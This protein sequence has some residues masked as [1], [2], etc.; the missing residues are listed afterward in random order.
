MQNQQPN[1]QIQMIPQ[2]MQLQ[3]IQI[4]PSGLSGQASVQGQQTTQYV[5]SQDTH[6]QIQNQIMQTQQLA[7][8]H[9]AQNN[10]N[11]SQA[12][13]QIQQIT[14]QQPKQILIGQQSVA[15][16]NQTSMENR[17]IMTMV[18]ISG[19]GN[20]VSGANSGVTN[21][22][23]SLNAM[24]NL[25]SPVSAPQH[26][27]IQPPPNPLAA[28][29][30]LSYSAT[31]SAILTNTTSNIAKDDKNTTKSDDTHKLISSQ[32]TTEPTVHVSVSTST[33]TGTTV[34]TVANGSMTI[35][36]ATSAPSV[37]SHASRDK[38][39]GKFY[40]SKMIQN[41]RKKT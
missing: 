8:H 21:T 18:S 3:Q 37:T 23:S 13:G 20:S 33:S 11:T 40:R 24:Q 7:M 29:T 22:V 32:S 4:Q 41:C 35:S 27:T 36:S 16:Q 25:S 9:Q 5:T 17:P 6:Q 38:Q 1:Q 31:P 2:Q 12:N 19:G 14:I 10:L 28:M 15:N 34:T 30:S 26:L 39:P